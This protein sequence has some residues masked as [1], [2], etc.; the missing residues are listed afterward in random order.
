MMNDDDS[1]EKEAPEPERYW[2]EEEWERSLLENEKLMDRYEEVR[3]QNPE[4]EWRDP[5]DLYMKVHHDIDLGEEFDG[6]EKELEEKEEI[7][8]EP[9]FEPEPSP[10]EKDARDCDDDIERIAA[11]KLAFEF[12]M[13]VHNYFKKH[14]KEELPREH[15]LYQ[16]DFHALRIPADIAGGDGLGYEP[17]TLCGNIVKNRWALAH[18]EKAEQILLSFPASEDL[19][20]LLEKVKPVKLELQ[21]RIAEL[22]SRVWW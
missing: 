18:A 8:E 21:N 4:R 7:E 22:R 12:A 15:I 10:S 2:T 14:W 5:S 19:R 11:Y 1:L 17:D 20:P 16:L 6:R 9:P 13:A 3:E